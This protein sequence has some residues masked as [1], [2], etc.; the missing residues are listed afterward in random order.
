MISPSDFSQRVLEP[1]RLAQFY[2]SAAWVIESNNSTRLH[3]RFALKP[4][5]C[6]KDAHSLDRWRN[7]RY[8]TVSL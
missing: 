4:I 1:L 5:C 2:A 7:H 3:W 8:L 6:V